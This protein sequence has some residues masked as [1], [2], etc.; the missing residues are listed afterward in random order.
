MDDLVI[1]KV[2]EEEIEEANIIVMGTCHCS[3]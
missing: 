1:E 2:T 3:N